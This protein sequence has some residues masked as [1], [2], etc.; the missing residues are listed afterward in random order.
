M[1]NRWALGHRDV[2]EALFDAIYPHLRRLA[3]NRLRFEHGAISIQPT[4]LAHEAFLAMV[5]Q[6]QV[7]W[8]SRGHFLAV[9][10]ISIRRILVDRSR[11]RLREKRG[12]GAVHVP[13]DT[14]DLPLIESR[15]DMLALD[16]A[17]I[18]LSGL[19]S[20]AAQ[21]VDLRFFAGLGV[22]D[23]AEVLGV[24]RQTVVRKWRFAKA[25]LARQ[26]GTTQ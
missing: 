23:T 15:V 16:G 24:S 1:L 25:F 17:L 13:L 21:I 22:D 11:H 14:L 8:E 10:A 18:K 4:E 20:I 7:D 19:S 5:D 26:L 2:E 6:R 12:A 9:A 3:K